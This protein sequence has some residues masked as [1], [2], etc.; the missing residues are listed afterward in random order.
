[1]IHRRIL[2]VAASEPDASMEAVADEVSGASP[3]LVERVLDEY[4]DPAS[5]TDS[6][7]QTDQPMNATN[8][9]ES[10]TESVTDTD[11]GSTAPND[12]D[13]ELADVSLS[14]KQRRTLRA[15]Y[16]RP[17]ASQGDLAEELDVTRATVSRRLNA[18]PG[19]EW[20]DRR[21]FAESVFG[22]ESQSTVEPEATETTEDTE[23]EPD[24]PDTKAPEAVRTGT[25]NAGVGEA[26]ADVEERLATIESRLAAGAAESGAPLPPELAHKVAHACMESDRLSEDEELAVLKALMRD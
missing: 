19:F 23:T 22:G 15:L 17:D 6:S 5:E 1:M 7:V 14:K 8:A 18:I 13:G 12:S 20:S 26:L 21:A 11:D 9:D 4:G 2:D 10:D 24:E 3:A 16:E 25:P